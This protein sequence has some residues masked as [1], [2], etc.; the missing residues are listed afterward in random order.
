MT[1][2]TYQFQDQMS[3]GAGNPLILHIFVCYS[4]PSFL[5]SLILTSVLPK[6][7]IDVYK[8]LAMEPVVTDAKM[9]YFQ[10][11]GLLVIRTSTSFL[12]KFHGR[13]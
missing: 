7:F 8:T 4:L 11:H 6:I 3:L 10:V 9:T 2:K 12:Q 5:S 13:P 1:A